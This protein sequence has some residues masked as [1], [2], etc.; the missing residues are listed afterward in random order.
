MAIN[1]SGCLESRSLI[2]QRPAAGGPA[3]ES[4]YGVS[5]AVA[6][7]ST[8]LSV[9]ESLR[10]LS[11]GAQDASAPLQQC[12]DSAS[13]GAVIALPPGRYR[14]AHGITLSKRVLL[15]SE[16]LD[17]AAPRCEAN[18]DA[19]CAEL[20]AAAAL[21]S[22]GGL[23]RMTAP[24][25]GI[26]HVII[27][28]N[29]TER[30]GS[31]AQKACQDAKTGY[32]YNM[33]L[34]CAD[35]S[36]TNSV[37]K[38]AL[39]GTGMEVAG[40]Q[41]RIRIERSTFAF[42]GRHDARM[43]WADGLTVHDSADANISDNEFRD[44]TDVDFIFGGCQNCRIQRNAIFHSD[45]FASASFVALHLQS[46][47]GG[48][49]GNFTGSD[50]SQNTVD[51]GPKRRCGFGLFV[52]GDPWY[53]STVYGGS[54][55][56]NQV[57]NAQQGVV[58]DKTTGSVEF[59]DNFS[60]NAGGGTK[61][62][63]GFRSTSDYSISPES[64]LDRSKDRVPTESYS[65]ANWDGCIPN[66]YDW[67]APE[68]EPAPVA[69]SIQ[70]QVRR[71]YREI[72]LREVDASGLATWSDYLSRGNSYGSL[73]RLLLASDEGL[74]V[75][76]NQAY[77]ELFGRDADPTGLTAH[78]RYLKSGA[79]LN[80]LYS[81]LAKS[82]EGV[83]QGADP[84]SGAIRGFYHTVLGREPDADGFAYHVNSARQGLPLRTILLNFALS[85]EALARS[86]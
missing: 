62:S 41:P 17:P 2:R 6:G 70:L 32:G 20:F 7:G 31:A 54:V 85:P 37:S 63:C 40:F 65:Q 46:W 22:M 24:G 81:V 83:S 47:P 19:R 51:C 14:I 30:Q 67:V 60:R 18:G 78:V 76:V 1:L 28:G 64:V 34:A 68:T 29:R 5:F 74:Q 80:E 4:V 66:F 52:G 86:L 77:R 11:S 44:N 55:H 39:C 53:A 15:A 13:D 38:L 48:T 49:S 12:I 26:D 71:A 9:C 23:I 25:A 82:P 45:D 59:Y 72:L 27:N 33:Q 36:F 42:N 61:A 35:C 57:V 21:Y 79:T 16:G 73:I 8:P 50:I 69:D 75:L 84:V 10:S 58:V 3:S 43:L 56:D